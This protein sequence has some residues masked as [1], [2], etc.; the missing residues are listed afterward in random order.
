MVKIAVDAMGGDHAPLAVVRGA[1]A[2]V[3][4]KVGEVVLVG[5]ENVIASILHG[6]EALAAH[7]AEAA[8]RTIR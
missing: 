2:A 8:V 3:R 7:P 1:E 4:E 5:D 6:M